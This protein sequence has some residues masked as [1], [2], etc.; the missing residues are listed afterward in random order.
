M[1]HVH[2][3][4]A[5]LRQKS[6]LSWAQPVASGSCLKI[7][8]SFPLEVILSHKLGR[9]G[10]SHPWLLS[11][12]AVQSTI[13][14][15]YGHRMLER[16]SAGMLG[17]HLQ[18]LRPTV[19]QVAPVTWSIHSRVFERFTPVRQS[20]RGDS[21]N[22]SSSKGHSTSRTHLL[23]GESGQTPLQTR[24]YIGGQL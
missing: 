6:R 10:S 19:S 18:V 4:S 24:V 12:E 8:S 22:P 2:P 3:H 20:I 7:G 11:R 1:R 23:P 9:Q 5:Q 17:V 13:R 21:D 15:Q 14:L 16:G